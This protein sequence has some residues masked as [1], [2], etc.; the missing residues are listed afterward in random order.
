MTA[1]FQEQL[2]LICDLQ[3]ID[4]NLH[5][6]KLVLET[7]PGK[8][9]EVEAAHA[10]IKGALDAAKSELAEVE[11]ARRTDEGELAAAVDHLRNREAKLYA[12][13]TNKEYQAAL[14]EISEGKR[15]NREREDRILQAMERIENLTQKITQLEKECADKEVAL[16]T[17]REAV[18]KEE[19]EIREHMKGDVERRPG[20]VGRIDKVLIRKYD[21]VRQRYAQAVAE[22]AD[23]ICQ[24]CSRRI[25]PQLFNEM[26]RRV[27][28]K[29]CPSCQRLIY[30]EEAKA[31]Q[32]KAEQVAVD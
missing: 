2:A 13:K 30:V 16:D 25:P 21:F 27:E 24:G 9:G 15:H 1:S 22:V 10:A 6:F 12:I 8:L 3:K 31:E 28:L 23:G 7:L 5:N 32:A 4:L 14:K 20:L 29:T 19:S 17:V 11:K 18:A 26:L